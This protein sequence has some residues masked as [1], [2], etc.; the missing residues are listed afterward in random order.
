[1]SN[2][3][4]LARGL[5]A[6]LAG[7]LVCMRCGLRPPRTPKH[8]LCWQCGPGGPPPPC[9]G[10]GGPY[11]MSGWCQHCHPHLTPS[12]TRPRSC[13][14]C[15]AWGFMDG[16]IC[17]ACRS[18]ARSHSVGPCTTCGR[19]VPLADGHCRLCRHQARVLTTGTH[20]TG[21]AVLH[22]VPITGQQLFLADTLR[23]ITRFNPPDQHRRYHRRTATAVVGPRHGAIPPGLPWPVQPELFKLPAGMVPLKILRG[24]GPRLAWYAHLVTAVERIGDLKGWTSDVRSS[25]ALTLEAVVALHEAGTPAYAASRIAH[26][27]DG[28]HRNVVRTLELLQYLGRLTDDRSDPAVHWLAEHLTALPDPIRTDVAD[29]ADV[30]RRGDN[31]HLPK[32]ELTW[33][34]YLLQ[35]L[36]I[37]TG[38]A[39]EYTALR[40]VTRDDVITALQQPTPRGGDGHTRLT[41]L[42]SLFAFLKARRRIFTDPTRRLSR[43]LTRRPQPSIPSRLPE[44]AFAELAAHE[45]VPAEWLILIL[46]GH[47]ALSAAQIRALAL[48]DVDL[49]NRDLNIDGAHRPIDNLTHAAITR[50]LDYRHH[51]WPRTANLH[52]L[53]TQQTAHNT[54]PVSRVWIR[55]A[56]R[57]RQ[58][59][60]SGLRQDRILDEAE[61]VGIPDPLHV[62]AIF[63]LHPDTAQR[64]V[65]AFYARADFTAPERG[66]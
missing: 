35:A 11:W 9:K 63:D 7:D 39:R 10:C 21:P 15:F 43:D 36:P 44:A 18:F 55:Y 24:D 29:W 49:P 54:E 1:M 65:D 2:R 8:C 17:K 33:K 41:A 26:L 42:R 4:V 25:V 62:A 58:A 50:Y 59:T 28:G 22:L 14:V 60:L 56:V 19:H 27:G 66:T 5:R 48:D 46:T 38:W 32:S 37:L 64:Y 34:N 12:R 53:I 51:R 47:Q 57:D 3:K 52:L 31:R 20:T 23:R 6:A 16:Y 13:R 30:L 40:E 61:A 45:P